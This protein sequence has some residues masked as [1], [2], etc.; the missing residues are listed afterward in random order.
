V[1]REA[2]TPAIVTEARHHSVLVRRLGLLISALTV[3]AIRTILRDLV[4][5]P[6]H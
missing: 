3:M 5:H 4:D 2:G 6:Y 1:G